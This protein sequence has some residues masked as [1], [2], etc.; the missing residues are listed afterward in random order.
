LASS[1]D[2]DAPAPDDGTRSPGAT[3]RFHDLTDWLRNGLLP[4]VVLVLGALLVARFVQWASQRYR[5][6]LDAEAR[7]TIEA[8]RVVSEA[9]KR[10]RAV[11]QAVEWTLV[12][13]TYFLAGVLAIR[14][15]GVPLPTL[16]APATV[17]GVALGF[18]AQQVVGDL[19][20]GFFLFSERQ[21]GIGDLIRL[22]QPG[23]TTGV[24]GTVEELT[25]RVTK[26]R[27]VTGEFVVVPNSAL[28]QVTNLSKDWSRVVLDVPIRATEDLGRAT[29]VLRQAAHELAEDPQWSPLLLGAPVMSGVETIEVGYVL[30][31]LVVRTLPGRQFDV[32]RELRYRCAAALQEAGISTAPMADD[33]AGQP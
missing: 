6:A 12:S 32:S 27:T 22:S 26:L 17:V 11:A 25:L 18:G 5:Q 8:G 16:V 3:V 21:F 7:D 15:L 31:R 1:A 33:S 10:S 29:D 4:T 23:Q 2:A 30:V 9:T 24:T 13:L 19:L 14:Q 20:A 28:R